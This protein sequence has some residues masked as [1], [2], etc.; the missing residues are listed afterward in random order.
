MKAHFV[1]SETRLTEGQ[2][3][4]TLCGVEILCAEWLFYWDELEIGTAS[5]LELP[6]LG[7][8]KCRLRIGD[9]VKVGYVYGVT[10]KKEQ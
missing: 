1:S 7:C 5:M 2:P 6:K 10:E 8:E 3:C 9:A 4:T